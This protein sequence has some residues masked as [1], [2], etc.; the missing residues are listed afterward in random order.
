MAAHENYSKDNSMQ[1]PVYAEENRLRAEIKYLQHMNEQ[2]FI[3]MS[4]ISQWTTRSNF[5]NWAKSQGW[6]IARYGTGEYLSSDTDTAWSS[7]LACAEKVNNVLTAKAV[8][9]KREP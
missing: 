1:H 2:M 6:D 7:W 9:A 8:V 4:S 3:A 5:E